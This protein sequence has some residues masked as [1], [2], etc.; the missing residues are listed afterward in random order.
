MSSAP[1]AAQGVGI[2]I[3]AHA[4]LASA[5]KACVLHVFPDA[6]AFVAAHDT[7]AGAAPADTEAQARA[8]MATLGTQRVLI[9]TDVFGA[10]PSNVGQKLADGQRVR[11]VTGVNV[12]MLLRAVTYRHENLDAVVGR[13][14]AGATQGIMSVAV[15]AP[16]N[17]AR[18]PLS[19][20]HDLHHHH[21]Q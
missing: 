6:H 7:L 17:Q 8:A 19:S 20:S 12:P 2:L 15:S 21:Q 4:P 11:M 5:L 9:A 1:V 14:L 18:S 16:Q 3:L 10:T 13:A